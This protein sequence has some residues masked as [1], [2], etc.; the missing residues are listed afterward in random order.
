MQKV[1]S[2]LPAGWVNQ[3]TNRR[4]HSCEYN[5][6]EICTILWL[7][8]QCWVG[9]LLCRYHASSQSPDHEYCLAV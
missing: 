1:T 4:Q 7:L 8:R 5:Y 2:L 3:E 6:F 9:G